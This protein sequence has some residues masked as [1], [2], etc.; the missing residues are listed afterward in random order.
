MEHKT[1]DG[2]T[3]HPRLHLPVQYDHR[4][5][6]SPVGQKNTSPLFGYI[7]KIRHMPLQG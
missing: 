5:T 4:S 7:G 3:H 1:Q 2:S 6:K